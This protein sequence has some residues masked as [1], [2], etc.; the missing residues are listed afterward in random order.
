MMKFRENE[1]AV[2]PVIGVIL[3]V[4]ITVILAAVIAAFVFGMTGNVQTTKTVAIGSA[5]NSGDLA[6]TVN[7]GADLPTLQQLTIT[8]DGAVPTGTITCNNADVSEADGILTLG[9]GKKFQVGNTITIEGQ[10]S[11]RL[12]VVGKWSDGAEQIILDRTY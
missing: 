1:E 5:L 4:A 6:L 9:A 2:S 12:L 11:G 8:I 10:N 3:M 7:G